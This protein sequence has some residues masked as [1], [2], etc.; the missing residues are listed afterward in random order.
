MKQQ[1]VSRTDSV[2]RP[3]LKISDPLNLTKTVSEVSLFIAHVSE[4]C[5]LD[6]A[7]WSQQ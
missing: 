7:D 4:F 3:V 6:L 5:W 2:F 1:F